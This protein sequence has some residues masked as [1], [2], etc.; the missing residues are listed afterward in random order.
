MTHYLTD[1]LETRT[2]P[3]YKVH[4]S[5]SVI[6]L[7]HIPSPLSRMQREGI[8]PNMFRVH[9]AEECMMLHISSV[10]E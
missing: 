3:Y 5:I 2:P 8:W 9:I 1:V 4:I 7:S 10:R 6:L